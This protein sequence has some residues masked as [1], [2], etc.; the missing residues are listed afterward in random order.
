M[1]RLGAAPQVLPRHILVHS[2]SPILVV[3]G[4]VVVRG[5]LLQCE[6]FGGQWCAVVILRPFGRVGV[7]AS[8]WPL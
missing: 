5:H 3:H 6:I 2:V 1:H 4:T 7:V 8:Q